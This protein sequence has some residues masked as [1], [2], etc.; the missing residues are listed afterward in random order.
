MKILNAAF[1]F[2]LTTTSAK[3]AS[4]NTH[5]FYSSTSSVSDCILIK[6][7][8][9]KLKPFWLQKKSDFRIALPSFAKRKKKSKKLRFPS[10]MTMYVLKSLLEFHGRILVL[11]TRNVS[12]EAGEAFLFHY[13]LVSTVSSLVGS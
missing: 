2:Y 3:N 9:P 7:V 12:L 6:I 11:H 10:G 13:T 8:H 1:S 5:S 4:K